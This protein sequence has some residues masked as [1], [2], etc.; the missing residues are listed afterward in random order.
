MMKGKEHLHISITSSA[1]LVMRLTPWCALTP[2]PFN[3][4]APVPPPQH[5][6]VSLPQLI[7]ILC[8]TSSLDIHSS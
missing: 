3:C 5:S 4:C 1:L 7:A 2:G 8:P 6:P